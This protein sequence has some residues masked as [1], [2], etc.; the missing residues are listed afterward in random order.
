[1]SEYTNVICGYELPPQNIIGQRTKIINLTIGVF[2]D[3]TLNNKYN[4]DYAKQPTGK[5]IDDSYKGSYSNVAEL[6]ECYDTTTIIKSIYIEGIGSAEPKA[7]GTSSEKSDYS[8][9]YIWGTGGTG[10]NAKVE[11]GCRLIAEEVKKVQEDSGNEPVTINSLTLDVFGFSRGAAAA[12]SFAS[13]IEA[14]HGTKTEG[15]N[16]ILRQLVTKTDIP[17]I[18]VRFIG[19]FDTVSSFNPGMGFTEFENDVPE[20]ALAIPRR[21]PNVQKVVHLVAA[22]EYRENFA[23]TTIDSAGTK[24]NQIILPGA[25]SDIGGG[26]S[27][28]ES[29]NILM[30]GHYQTGERQCRGYMSL[31]ELRREQWILSNWYTEMDTF[32]PNGSVRKYKDP[33]RYIKNDYAKILLEMMGTY[34]KNEQ[35]CFSEKLKDTTQIPNNLSE[36]R[37]RILSIVDGGALLYKVYTGRVAFIGSADDL[38]KVRSIRAE[39]LHLSSRNE[40]R[41]GATSNNEREIIVDGKSPTEIIDSPIKQINKTNKAAISKA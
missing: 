18:K 28:I 23:L 17:R 41:H 6:Y 31:E 10:I 22:D 20:L 11:R 32:V 26:Y 1:M 25:H 29:E 33:N 4:L 40:M 3:G 30:K 35:L 13:Q 16:V 9:G 8:R 5:E 12:R 7:D 2:F 38:S 27:D 36:I 39:Y 14:L 24:G 15:K 19:L 34:A 21:N 37:T